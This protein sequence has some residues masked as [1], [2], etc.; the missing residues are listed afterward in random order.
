[1]AVMVNKKDEMIMRLVHYFV[2]EEDYSPIVVNGVKDEIWLQNQNGPY[3]IVRINSNYIHNKEQYEYDVM[4]LENVM[5][6]VKKKTLS[7]SMNALN[8]LLDVNEGVSIENSK[9]ISSVSLK[10]VDIIENQE[11]LNY[12]PNINEK[13]MNDEA[14][15]DLMI[16]VTNDINKKTEKENRVYESIFKQKKIVVTNVLIAINVIAFFASFI[17]TQGNFTVG[18]MLG[19]GAI[20]YYYLREGEVWRLITSGFLHGGIMHL[21]FNMYSLYVIGTQIE[22]FIGKKKYLIIYF[23]SMICAGLMSCALST[24]TVS[25]GASGAIFGL[26]GSLV[27]FGYYYRL[28]LGSV[29][30]NQII[31]LIALNLILGFMTTGIDNAAHIGGLIA[32]LFIA[33]GLGVQRKEK[34][35]NK[36]NGIIVSLLYLAF[37][38]YLVFFR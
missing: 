10:N 37:L 31:P 35:S 14:G 3:K 16:D 19:L 13:L 12:Y 38:V 4:K 33:M 34:N 21:L 7:W 18:N 6:Q 15:L 1:M 23:F 30:K 22:N 20:N 32:G 29:L 2:T 11:I 9:H 28:Y 8:I 36:M 27:Y 24:N 17:L 5:G 25:V 26:L